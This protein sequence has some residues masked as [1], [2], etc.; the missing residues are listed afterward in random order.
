MWLSYQSRGADRMKNYP[1]IDAY[2]AAHPAEVQDKLQKM[3]EVIQAA[4]PEATEAI[5][6][7]MPTYKLK[8][9]LVHFAAY[10][11][12]IGFYPTPSAI[13]AFSSELARYK[14]SKGAVQFPLDQPIFYDLVKRMTKY[15]VEE[16]VGKKTTY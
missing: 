11:H 16:L 3:R 15:R 6:Y 4:A 13:E 8:G 10:A 14:T 1:S 7:G 12:H 9:N 2:I 5:S